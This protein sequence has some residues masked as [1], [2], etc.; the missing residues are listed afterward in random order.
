[1]HIIATLSAN[2]FTTVL[3]KPTEKHD[4]SMLQVW[5][6]IRPSGLP[7]WLERLQ[8]HYSTLSKA[9]RC[10]MQLRQALPFS[11]SAK[12]LDNRQ[13]YAW[14]EGEDMVWSSHETQLGSNQT[15]GGVIALE[16]S[17]VEGSLALM[18]TYQ[19]DAN[20]ACMMCHAP[21]NAALQMLFKVGPLSPF[22]YIERPVKEYTAMTQV[23][24]L[25]PSNFL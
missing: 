4:F 16:Q 13:P 17:S 10:A 25:H 18:H 2:H 8:K 12:K 24:G 6:L 19:L 20:I 15:T 22:R 7:K 21:N 23:L 3:S 5:D 1:M 9:Q 11:S 14:F